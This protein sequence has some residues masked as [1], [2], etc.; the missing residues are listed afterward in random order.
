MSKSRNETGSMRFLR[1]VASAFNAAAVMRAGLN[2]S[3]SDLRALGIDARSFRD[4]RR[5]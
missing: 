4:I 3:D 2:P 5:G 1:A